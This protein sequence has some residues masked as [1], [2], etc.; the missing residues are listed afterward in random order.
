MTETT[1]KTV[2]EISLDRCKH[3]GICSHFCPAGAITADTDGRPRLTD[4]EACTSCRLCEQLCPDFAI[5]MVSDTRGIAPGEAAE[6]PTAKG[7]K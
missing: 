7:R 4:P 5:E 6:Q 1:R 3:C 2:P